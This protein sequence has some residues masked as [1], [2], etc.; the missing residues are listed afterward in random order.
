MGDLYKIHLHIFMPHPGNPGTRYPGTRRYPGKTYTGARAPA[1]PGTR[2]PRVCIH[3][4]P[5][6]RVPGSVSRF[7]VVGKPFLCH[8]KVNLQKWTSV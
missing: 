3:T 6:T 4:Y 8:N 2:V 1:Y 7:A 5:I